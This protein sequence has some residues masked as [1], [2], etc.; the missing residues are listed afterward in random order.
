MITKSIAAEAAR[1]GIS[2]NAIA[3]GAIE[4]SIDAVSI[5]VDDRLLNHIPCRRLC[6]L[7]EILKVVV[8]TVLEA[9]DYLTGNTFILDG[10]FSCSYMRDW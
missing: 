10:G 7:S 2:A 4:D 5:P 6:T 8:F 3:L 1:Y 9:P